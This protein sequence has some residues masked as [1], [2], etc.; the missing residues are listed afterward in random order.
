MANQRGQ[1]ALDGQTNLCRMVTEKLTDNALSL[2]QEMAWLEEVLH[3]RI[4]M[5]FNQQGDKQIT[6]VVPPAVNPDGSMYESFV[7]HYELTFAE[8]LLLILGL[9][10]YLKPQMLDIF[11]KHNE[12]LDRGYT[13]FGGV[14]GSHHGGFIPTG[15]TAMFILAGDNLQA[16]FS[17]MALFDGEHYFAK[18][19]ILSLES[20]APEEPFLS[21]A[22]K[23]SREFIDLFTT[24]EMR[25]PNFSSEF[26]ARLIET[27]LDWGDL[28]LDANVTRQIDEIRAWVE[29]GH[30]VMND[31]G[32]SKKLRPGYRSLFYGP[33]GTGKTMTACLLGKTTGKDVYK[34]DLS[35]VVSKYIGETEKNLSK[36]FEQA[37]HKGWILFFDE[38]D[39]LFGKRTSVDDAH[40]RYANQEV[41]FLL[42]RIETFDGVVILASNLKNNIDEAFTRRF[43]SIVNF[44]M[45][46]AQERYKIWSQGI[47]EKSRFAPDVNLKKI[48]DKYELSGGSIMNVVRYVSLMAQTRNSNELLLD[49]IE[50]GIKKEFL[51]EGKTL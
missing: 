16:R 9:V 35:M 46:R 32:L 20:V 18:H 51:K 29:H 42:Q 47:S 43:E 39:A 24:G 38:A 36:V 27:D 15:E 14:K 10:P 8:R 37:E 26:P 30:K 19:N 31:W 28:I 48:A 13:E 7:V 41:S 45:P 5:H 49:E 25:K 11:F 21:G 40:D 33:P 12:E 4:T 22:I 23:V 3:T 44:Q 17:L 6:D 50:A 2:E 34:I 1:I